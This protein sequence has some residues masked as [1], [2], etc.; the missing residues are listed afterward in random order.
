VKAAARNALRRVCSQVRKAT[1]AEGVLGVVPDH[2]A[3]PASVEEAA[4]VMRVAAE[5][6]LTVVPRGG[7]TR[8]DWG[9][10]PA[11][12]DL[13]L[14]TAR[15]DQVIEHAAGDLIVRVQAGVPMERL[16][17][18]LAR[19]GQQLALD[20][21]LPGSTVGGTLATAAAGPRRLRYGSPRD[22]LIGIT[23]VRAD[24]TVAK[25]G[26]K[27]VKNVAGYDLG[28]LLAGSY[29]TL[30]LIVE[31]AF[32]LHP[33][34]SAQAYLT[35]ELARDQR[36]ELPALVR[37]LRAST[38]VP[39]AIEVDAPADGPLTVAVLVDGVPEAIGARATALADLLGPDTKTAEEPPE[40][41]GTYPDGTTLIETTSG[42]PFRTP[43]APGPDPARMSP[44]GVSPASVMA[45]GVAGRWGADGRGF[46]GLSG[47]VEEVAAVVR[48][49]RG[50]GTA[51]VRYA[52]LEVREAVDMWGAVPGLGLMR[53]VKD[54]FDPGHRLS[55]GR[56]VGGI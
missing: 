13:L 11:S 28:K 48:E 6:G 34:P 56:F 17:E 23:I 3:A 7:E 5:H 54:Q 31:A 50:R 30:G 9:L 38:A 27:V 46:V 43:L 26:G 52:P 36:A 19:A 42:D 8:L 1:T 41:W 53:R 2:V 29:G 10:P 44:A 18:V 39:T 37:A 12:C 16:A 14:D 25:S 20:T 22:L 15:L 4:A 47:G 51:V 40:W 35:R 21:P 49:L 55:P 24:G 33:L 32:R 45:G